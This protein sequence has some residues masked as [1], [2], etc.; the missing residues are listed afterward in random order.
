MS[1]YGWLLL[2]QCCDDLSVLP[3]YAFQFGSHSPAS[4][5]SLCV[6]LFSLGPVLWKAYSDP[7]EREMGALRSSTQ[8][9][10]ACVSGLRT[11]LTRDQ[12]SRPLALHWDVSVRC[13]TIVLGTSL[14]IEGRQPLIIH[15]LLPP[16]QHH[17][18]V[19]TD[20]TSRICCLQSRLLPP[21]PE[22]YIAT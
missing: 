19:A 3:E 7:R 13:T 8:S 2:H 11:G 5:K 9:P 12:V 20:H 6:S 15:L 14:V 4:K 18:L 21:I 17:T 22:L 1:L 16:E 10:S